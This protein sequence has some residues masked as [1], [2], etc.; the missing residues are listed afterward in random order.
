MRSEQVDKMDHWSLAFLAL[1]CFA[2]SRIKWTNRYLSGLSMRRRTASTTSCTCESTSQTTATLAMRT[3]VLNKLT[4]GAFPAP[5][6]YAT[7]QPRSLKRC[8]LSPR[9]SR[10]EEWRSSERVT[11]RPMGLWSWS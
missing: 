10:L 2:T 1:G 5:W 6:G 7:L 11:L 9:S 8:S 4:R 3:C